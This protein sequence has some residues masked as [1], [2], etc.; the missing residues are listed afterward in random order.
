M[1]TS[2]GGAG[3]VRRP[4][5]KDWKDVL[6]LDTDAIERQNNTAALKH[7]L[8]TLGFADF[9]GELAKEDDEEESVDEEEDETEDLLQCKVLAAGQLALQYTMQRLRELEG[10]RSKMYNVR[11]KANA[12]IASL[13]NA[14]MRRK[15]RSSALEEEVEQLGHT[16]DMYHTMLATLNPELHRKVQIH[17]KKVRLAIEQKNENRRRARERALLEDSER[18]A[19]LTTYREEIDE[20][21]AML[22]AERDAINREK[23]EWTYKEHEMLA[24]MSAFETQATEAQIERIQQDRELAS[25]RATYAPRGTRPTSKGVEALG[26]DDADESDAGLL[27]LV[28]VAAKWGEIAVDGA[29]IAVAKTADCRDV[30]GDTSSKAFTGKCNNKWKNL[31]PLLRPTQKGIGFGWIKR[32][33]DSKFSKSSDAQDELDNTII[34]AVLGP[35]RSGTEGALY[36]T[37]HHHTLA[38]LDWSGFEDVKVTVQISCDRRDLDYQSFWKSMSAESLVYANARSHDSFDNLPQAFD[39]S[40]E[41]PRAFYFNASASS[42]EDDHW[43][44]FGSFVRKTKNQT[45]GKQSYPDDCERGYKRLCKSS[46][47]TG[48]PFY[49]FRWAYFLNDAY[50]H[51][52]L[53]PS[54][55]AFEEFRTCYVGVE[56]VTNFDAISYKDWQ[57]CADLL[58]ALCRSDAAA[59]YELPENLF[60]ST[61]DFGRGLPGFV[62]GWTPIVDEDADCKI[63]TC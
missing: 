31:K 1:I 63:S 45:C 20:A 17:E 29:F 13:R 26:E 37:D 41:L 43:R 25:I 3:T 11:K 16:M 24:K 18:E 44:S 28:G 15:A 4:T 54:R 21:N 32:K 53:W 27:S 56:K 58:V 47:D 55:D 62:S 5:R 57:A 36:I 38:A 60:S 10:G 34:P 42:F 46:D 14:L 61:G 2:G 39:P 12:R 49:E 59:S 23:A 52:A 40:I 35:S 19:K 22:S 6:R 9:G 51:D 48:I 8:D 7:L 30:V 50:V 33:V